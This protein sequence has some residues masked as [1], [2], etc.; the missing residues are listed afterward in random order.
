MHSFALQL[1][2]IIFP[3]QG[4]FFW[5][6]AYRNIIVPDGIKII[7]E[8]FYEDQKLLFYEKIKKVHVFAG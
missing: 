5:Y 8:I 1:C 7:M 2:S 6:I 4:V 3:S